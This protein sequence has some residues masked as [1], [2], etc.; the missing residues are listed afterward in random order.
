MKYEKW[1]NNEIEQR[2]HWSTIP[3]GP[4]RRVDHPQF[5]EHSTEYTTQGAYIFPDTGYVSD[6]MMAT[7]NI[8]S[9][10][11]AAGAQ[12][13]FNCSV[14]GVRRTSADGR[15]TSVKLADGTEVDT[16]VLVNAAGPHSHKVN[17][18]VF[19]GAF[20]DSKINTRPLRVEVAYVPVE[21]DP[22]RL[23]FFCA[24]F[25]LGCYHRP[26]VGNKFLVGSIEPKC[27]PL[28]WVDDPDALDTNISDE[29]LTHLYRVSM[30]LPF[31]SIPNK[32]TS[33]VSLYDVTDD[34]TPIYDQSSIPGY[35]MAIGT[36]GNQF[37]CAAVVGQMMSEIITRCE[38]GTDQDAEPLQFRLRQ[39]GNTLDTSIFSRLRSLLA[40]SSSVFA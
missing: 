10:A 38:N 4:P 23:D 3:C 32:H 30:R 25:E 35:Y 14:V 8:Q 29:Y 2:L 26:D 7:R 15:I 1:D 21:P 20:N 16:H 22:N 12:F 17:E 39:T 28:E 34:W 37:K 11:C 27:D 6:P 9:A 5:G 31:L 13:R 19:D 36:S 24:D 40:T 33:I 18:M